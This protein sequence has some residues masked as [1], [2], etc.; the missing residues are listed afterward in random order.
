MVISLRIQEQSS[1]SSEGGTKRSE[2]DDVILIGE[3]DKV[4]IITPNRAHP[5][6]DKG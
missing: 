3:Q 5:T 6:A 2:R 4:K 1:V